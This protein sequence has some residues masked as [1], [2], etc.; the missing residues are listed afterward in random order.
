MTR[1]CGGG[2]IV[3]SP[4]LGGELRGGQLTSGCYADA[5]RL[6]KWRYDL[7]Q[8]LI[9]I[10]RWETPYLALVQEK[11]RSPLLDSYFA[12]TANL[13]THTFYMAFLPMMF[14]CGYTTWGRA[15]TRMLANG[16][17]WTGVVK[18]MLCLPRPLSPPLVRITMSGSAALEYGFPSTHSANAVSVA[19]YI[20]HKLYKIPVDERTTLVLMAMAACYWYGMSIVLG[21]L[22]CGMHGFFD[23]IVGSIIGAIIAV[24]ELIF[25]DAYD[26]W[27]T[28]GNFT[29]PLVIALVIL[30][31][32]RIHPEPA[33][34][35]PCF[36]DSVAFAAV[37]IGVEVGVWHFSGTRFAWNDPVPATVPFDYA[38]LGFVKSFMRIVL[39]VVGIFS[40]RGVM[41]PTL[42]RVLPPIFRLT[43]QFGVDLPRK[44]FLRASQYSSVPELRKDDNVIPPA[45]EIP[46]LLSSKL[47]NPLRRRNVSIGPQS[48]ADAWEALAYREKRR[49]ESLTSIAESPQRPTFE[50]SKTESATT[51]AQHHRAKTPSVQISAPDDDDTHQEEITTKKKS[52]HTPTK[53]TL[54]PTPFASRVQSYEQMM[55]ATGPEAFP[56][57]YAP[58]LT[59]PAVTDHGLFTPNGSALS[60]GVRGG[61]PNPLDVPGLDGSMLSSNPQQAAER[62]AERKIFEQLQRP[63]VRYDV[64]VV[65][66]LIVY[67]GMSP[68]PRMSHRLLTLCRHR[69]ACRR[70]QPNSVRACWSRGREQT[71]RYH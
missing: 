12:V 13:G 38:Q 26:V 43:E 48:E 59:P 62:E 54:P 6:P 63:R 20:L 33:D 15:L 56:D 9:P 35:C 71:V 53:I 8:K 44:F 50:R 1:A 34:N 11:L 32:V 4:G 45:S 64:E 2:I 65:T 47:S 39:G 17:F 23:V 19:I 60:I 46:G 27:L 28:D 24:V 42:L 21:R 51:S 69:M 52:P 41:K 57:F 55:G 70:G 66:K 36:D 5:S 49:R 22:Y 25:S 18:D 16:V 29:A 37:V 14:W 61:P 3:R 30:V 58:P 68:S 67:A 7:R 40:W 31:L 10:V